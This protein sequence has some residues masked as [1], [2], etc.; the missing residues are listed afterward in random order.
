MARPKRYN[1]DYHTHDANMRNDP[2]IKA[3]RNK[4]SHMGYAV[5]NYLLEILTDADHFK[6]EWTDLNIEIFAGDFDT[7]TEELELIVGYLLKL[8]L[9]QKEGDF[10]L[11]EKH[12]SN[13]SGL[14][15]KRETRAGKKPPEGENPEKESFGNP[16]PQQSTVDMSFGLPKPQTNEVSGVQKPQSKVKESIVK[17][18]KVNYSIVNVI[19]N[20]TLSSECEDFKIS[21]EDKEKIYTHFTNW[22]DNNAPRVN[23]LKESFTP[24]QSIKL[25]ID[26]RG[27]F[28]EGLLKTMH[29]E[30]SLSKKISADIVF[31]DWAERRKVLPEPQITDKNTT[32]WRKF[33]KQIK[34]QISPEEYAKWFESLSI[35]SFDAVS[36]RLL[37][38]SKESAQHLAN[39]YHQVVSPIVKIVFGESL[40]VSY[41]FKNQ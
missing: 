16:E 20:Y 30:E 31:R 1:A 12:I 19:K 24:E 10:L 5:W 36:L 18:S 26:Y 28:I 4:F 35:V 7:S 8:K 41:L 9:V 38:V 21:N 29:N 13:F 33:T 11:C 2:R 14:I 23:A 17:E 40:K 27:E 22:I 25:M 37:T 15:T 3:V 6:L 32:L 34:G 39:N